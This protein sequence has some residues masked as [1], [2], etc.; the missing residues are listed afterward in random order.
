MHVLLAQFK[1]PAS[2]TRFSD[3]IGLA[4]WK[5]GLDVHSAGVLIPGSEMARKKSVELKAIFH[6]TNSLST[7]LRNLSSLYSEV[8][9]QKPDL[10]IF[11]NPEAS[12][13]LPLLKVIQPELK[14]V[15]DLQ[16]NH[17][18]NLRKQSHPYRLR[19]LKAVASDFLVRMGFF[20]TDRIW[21]AEKV[22]EKQLNPPAKK[23]ICLENKP[24]LKQAPANLHRQD[25]AFSFTGFITRESGIMRAVHF[26]NQ[27]RNWNPIWK[28]K[29]C[30]YCP[31]EPLRKE[32]IS[33]DFVEFVRPDQWASQEEISNCI[34]N[35]DGMLM[36]YIETEANNGKTP[37]KWFLA[38]A[39][40]VPVVY[41]AGT[42]LQLPRSSSSGLS[43]DFDNPDA[44]FETRWKVFRNNFKPAAPHEDF[45]FR[46]EIIRE[47]IIRLFGP[48]FAGT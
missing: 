25:Y 20:L 2:E 4:L 19:W 13:L 5:L 32:I 16:E 18:L 28:L 6:K 3:R 23:F 1:K 11:S 17:G 9:I 21:L 7:L 43:V 33:H 14:I 30:G 36:P 10:L 35:S 31:D 46:E 12:I 48:S 15:F 34:I 41:N 45:F 29:V 27:L 39:L 38:T 24:V 26:V 37:S 40:R 8:A 22:Y 42:Q 47:E 44:G